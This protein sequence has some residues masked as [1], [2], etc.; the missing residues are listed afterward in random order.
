[1]SGYPVFMKGSRVRVRWVETN[2]VFLGRII[3]AVSIVKEEDTSMDTTASTTAISV[4]TTEGDTTTS[5]SNSRGVVCYDVEYD[6]KIKGKTCIETNITPDRIELY[7]G[8]TGGR[9]GKRGE[10][11]QTAGA[12]ETD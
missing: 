5:S 9:R 11:I 1:M 12:R 2:D 6:E 8:T 7:C 10:L 4:G 3:N